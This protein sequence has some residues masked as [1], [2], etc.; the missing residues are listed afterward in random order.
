VRS[1]F[2]ARVW[3]AFVAALLLA[4]TMAA[5]FGQEGEPKVVD[6]VIAQVNNDVI[7]LSM[8]KREIKEAIDARKADGVPEQQA[9]QEVTSHQAELI[10]NLVTEQL[11]LQ[12]G[13]DLGYTEDVEAEVNKRMLDV[14][15]E[16]GI[17][18]IADLDE[19]LRQNGMDPAGIRQALRAEIMKQMVLNR[20]V[21]A[22]IFYG[23]SIEEVKKY[24]ETHRDK[25]RRPESVTLSE[26]W[27]S[28]AGK[29]EAEVRAKAMQLVLQA[30]AGADFAALAVANS[31]REQ[32]GVRVAPQTK[33]KV[34]TYQ[35][36]EMR[37]EIV[38][39]IKDV[40]V[41]GITDPLRSAE[42]LQI[43]RVDER[44]PAS[45]IS[46]FNEN[47]VREAI[48]NERANK[49]R[50]DYLEQL[51]KDAYIKIATPYRESVEPLLN[52]KTTGDKK[53]AAK[54]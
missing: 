42:G 22:K 47:Q 25:F 36:P 27:L 40:K 44:T 53:S 5:A 7:T 46:A 9:T 51:R 29:P 34:G 15:Q 26:I 19:A 38:A 50:A 37:P 43:L 24:Y 23:L 30:R 13:K 18:T 12:K 54:Q 1:K 21:D 8:V 33:G 52:I 41:G 3:M 31:E 6:E 14:A 2:L 39:A 28:L 48:T 4:T 16:R 20:D 10:A 11:L 35:V 17:K 32:G 45:D 49:E